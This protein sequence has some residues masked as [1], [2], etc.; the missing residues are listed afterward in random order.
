MRIPRRHRPD[1]WRALAPGKVNLC[2]FLGKLRPDGRH[3]L[4]TLFQSV[5]LADEL[6]LT[7][8]AEGSDEVI[9]PGIEEPNLV[10][11]A[12]AGLRAE[13]W[14]GPPVRIEVAKWI[15]VAGGMGG[16]SA[17]AAAAIRLAGAVASVPGEI[18]QPL[19][20][21]LGADVPSQLA[22]GVV[23]G[24]GAGDD[25]EPAPALAEHAY[26]IVP[27]PVA[28]ATADVYGEADRLGLGREA[29]ELARCAQGLRGALSPG[30]RLA[31]ALLVNDLEPAAISLC[32]Q[33]EPALQAAHETGADHV[34]VS[35][36]GPT[37]AA[38]FWGPDARERSVDAET[39]LAGRYPEAY[40]AEP[41]EGA[42]AAPQPA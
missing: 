26:V 11:A 35:G 30:A 23:L 36:S 39:E 40:A 18:A 34:L 29:G 9:C 12:L 33:I 32:P 31:N 42:F 19:A 24:T 20:G 17:D 37:V 13:G 15:P 4:V 7:V 16:G 21:R 5:S 1:R 22:P 2:L 27:L 41:V 25:V 14:A 38:L 6:E 10:S 3:E 8:L 28:L